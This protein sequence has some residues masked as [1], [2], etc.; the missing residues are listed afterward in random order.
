MTRFPLPDRP[1]TAALAAV[2]SLAAGV[3]LA[4]CG[5]GPVG[6]VTRADSAGVA[7]VTS[8]GPDRILSWR[9]AERF[10]LGGD[11]DGPASF[12]ALM[13]GM[14]ATDA[15]GRIH[16]LDDAAHRVVVFDAAGRHLRTF[17]REGGGPGELEM[18]SSIAVDDGVVGV[19]DYGK[20]GIV[21]WGPDGSPLP[22]FISPA[23]YRGGGLELRPTGAVFTTTDVRDADAMKDALVV[24]D[25]AYE[26][27]EEG[28]S[29]LRPVVSRPI[30]DAP[31][32]V[33]ESCRIGFRLP[34]LFHPDIEWAPASGERV[35]VSD[36][37]G[38]VVDVYAVAATATERVASYRRALEPR[39]ASR[40]LAEASLGE[41]MTVS[42]GGGPPCTIPPGEVIE[43]RGFAD[44]IPFI[45]SLV[46]DPAGRIW[47]ERVTIGDEPARVDLLGP[48]GAYLG[49]LLDPPE[50]IAFLPNGDLL[51]VETDELDVDRLVV[52]RVEETPAG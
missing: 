29:H 38:Y 46:V 43:A 14:V 13:R 22:A 50:P 31:M 39:P 11:D 8:E 47:V 9:F 33:F 21:R 28:W 1:A 5:D 17:G 45:E 2:V 51:A 48:D 19:W 44:R 23:F 12:Y 30:P 18:P 25:T 52:Y 41:G 37:T 27:G 6:S 10:R 35:V 7:L 3:L 20:T 36:E 42:A 4:G 34:P 32:H 24:L 40:E 15:D 49:T 26:G 16:V